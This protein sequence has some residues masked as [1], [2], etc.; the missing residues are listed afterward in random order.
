MR[1]QL[2]TINEQSGDPLAGLAIQA[3]EFFVAPGLAGFQDLCKAARKVRL[4]QG[5]E[6]WARHYLETAGGP[7]LVGNARVIRSSLAL[8]GF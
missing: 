3:E 5:V 7:V 2:Q 6:A 8:A 1:Q 4:G